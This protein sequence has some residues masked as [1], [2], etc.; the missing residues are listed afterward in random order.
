VCRQTRIDKNAFGRKNEPTIADRNLNPSIRPGE[1]SMN[2]RV[3]ALVNQA[4][5][6]PPEEQAELLDALFGLVSPAQGDLESGWV[7]ECEDR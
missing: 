5:T 3:E 7:M 2:A 6:W 1:I 4:R